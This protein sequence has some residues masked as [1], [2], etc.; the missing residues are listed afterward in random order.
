M[1]LSLIVAMSEN[2]VIGVNNAIPWH[3][4][5]DLKHF[6]AL[7]VNKPIIMGRKTFESIGRPLPQRENI[8]LTRDPAFTAEGIRVA[9]S[10]EDAVNIALEYV[11]ASCQSDDDSAG[12]SSEIMLIGGAQ[13]YALALEQNLIDTIYLTTVHTRIDGD[14]YFPALDA[15]AWRVLSSETHQADPKHCFSYTFETLARQ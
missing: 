9:L 5:N 2:G 4:P 1:A 14:A 11:A 10:L 8:V 12:V 13:L 15:H 3:L 6:K 7:T